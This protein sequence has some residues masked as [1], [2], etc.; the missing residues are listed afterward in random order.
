M[1]KDFSVEA[2]RGENGKE[3]ESKHFTG[4]NRVRSTT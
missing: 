4:V 1:L 3:E 2:R